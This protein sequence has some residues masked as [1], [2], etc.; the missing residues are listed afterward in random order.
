MKEATVKMYLVAERYNPQLGTYL[1]DVW[2]GKRRDNKNTVSCSFDWHGSKTSL[3]FFK[4]TGG[5][6]K[7][8]YYAGKDN[9]I[10]GS[11]SYYAFD[12]AEDVARYL[13]DK[14]AE[15]RKLEE[16]LKKIEAAQNCAA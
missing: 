9:S 12:M 7:Q 1:F 14:W 16:C 8:H 3:K 11:M 5:A 6:Y 15:S 10:Y 2:V 13:K 4:E